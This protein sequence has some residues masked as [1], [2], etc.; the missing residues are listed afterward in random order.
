MQ[1][2]PGL[3]DFVSKPTCSNITQAGID[4]SPATA[5]GP[6]IYQI[7]QELFATDTSFCPG[8]GTNKRARFR[9]NAYSPTANFFTTQ[10]AL[11]GQLKYYQT[12]GALG[13]AP[14]L[15]NLTV[16]NNGQNA[17]FDVNFCAANDLGQLRIGLRL[18]MG[19]GA[20]ATAQ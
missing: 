15:Q 20:C 7:T 16:S 14:G 9:V 13:P 3:C 11:A 17:T 12:S 6:V 18:D 19:N 5:T 1:P 2:G 4:W 8:T 10:T